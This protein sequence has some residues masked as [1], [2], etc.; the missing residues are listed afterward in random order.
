MS[1]TP[2]A[3]SSCRP[4]G[5]TPADDVAKTR[6][7]IIELVRELAS[8]HAIEAVGIGA[9]GWIDA[10]RSTVLFAQTWPG[11]TSRCA[12]TS[13]PPPACR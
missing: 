13:A 5:D 2:P 4:D 8:G 12:T 7:V 10:S 6:D 11:G 1:W 3:R 9:A